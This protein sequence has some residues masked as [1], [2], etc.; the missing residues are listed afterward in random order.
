MPIAL[1]IGTLVL[2]WVAII[3]KPRGDFP[4]HWELGRRML[5]GEYI[6]ERGLN[7]VYP[8]FWAL[9]HAP[10]ALV[11]VHLAQIIAYVLA[12]LSV[13]ALL[14]ILHRLSREELPLGSDGNFWATSLA[15]TLAVNFLSRD[16]PE[17][18]VNTAL[19]A[20][21][22]YAIYLWVRKREVTAGISL[23]LAAALKCTPLLF[24]G[25]FALK[26]QWRVVVTSTAAFSLFTLAPILVQGPEQYV[27]A[28]R[29]W[30]TFVALG[31]ADPDP[32]RGPLGEEKVENLALRPALARYLMHL[33][34]GHLGRPETS[35]TPGRPNEPP[36][37]YYLQFINLSP[38]HAGIVVKAIMAGLLLIVAWSLRSK[39]S[40]RGDLSVLYE[41]AAVSLLL[42]LYSPITWKQHCVGV[43][44]AL[45]LICRHGFAGQPL[46]RWVVGA[47]TVYAL[48][49]AVLSRGVIGRDL[50]KLLDGYR[51][52]TIAILLLMAAVLACRRA[53]L[54]AHPPDKNERKRLP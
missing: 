30:M 13:A 7:L 22:W 54:T 36:S 27:R 21:T 50:V 8:P 9:A 12:P 46:P 48:F 6:Y 35:D 45:F 3:L 44:P 49:A 47:V 15:V 14:R 51:V 29:S 25:Y 37:P 17:I 40:D 20:L 33:P 41:C 16:L 31:I 24:V 39:I 43:L 18:G 28:M 42:L 2:Y 10:L 38:H 34:Y 1:G 4:H 19:V 53:W 26:R 52:K 11:E 5:S 32:S 23:G